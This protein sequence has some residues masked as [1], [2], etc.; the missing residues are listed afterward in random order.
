MAVSLFQVDVPLPW[1]LWGGG[2]GGRER[3]AR[4]DGSHVE[5]CLGKGFIDFIAHFKAVHADAGTYLRPAEGGVGVVTACHLR[6]CLLHYALHSA[7]PAGVYS[8][9]RVVLGVIYE[10][11]DAVGGGYSENDAG[12]ISHH[13]VYALHQQLLRLWREGEV[14]FRYKHYA[15]GVCLV[16]SCEAQLV[17]RAG[18]CSVRSG[19]E[20]L[21]DGMAN[22]VGVASDCSV[23]GESHYIFVE[24]VC[25]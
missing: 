6:Q 4:G 22:L 11:G 18:S 15:V 17:L 21:A 7:A 9:R 3:V 13:C 16:W 1:P 8:R 5:A 23:G 25:K 12:Q 24:V 19:L 14:F 20:L 10:Y 2:F